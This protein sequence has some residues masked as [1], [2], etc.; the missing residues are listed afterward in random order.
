MLD[1]IKK[2]FNKEEKRTFENNIMETKFTDWVEET[3]NDV[4]CHIDKEEK[5]DEFRAYI[6]A[7]LSLKPKLKAFCKCYDLDELYATKIPLNKFGYLF[8]YEKEKFVLQND[9][10]RKFVAFND[11][12]YKEYDFDDVNND[13]DMENANG[14]IRW[15]CPGEINLLQTCLGIYAIAGDK[16]LVVK[17]IKYLNKNF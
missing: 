9:C 15:T 8:C 16:E 2:M 11:D 6:S 10:Q 5:K 13:V 3:K 4:S 12:F 7:N 17:F 1:T 14:E